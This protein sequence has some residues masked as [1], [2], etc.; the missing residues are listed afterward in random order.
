MR[1]SHSQSDADR[2]KCSHLS[3]ISSRAK[4]LPTLGMGTGT[5]HNRGSP[6]SECQ[7]HSQSCRNS[8]N[9]IVRHRVCSPVDRWWTRAPCYV[10]T[11]SFPGSSKETAP[12]HGHD[13]IT[14]TH[15]I[16]KARPKPCRCPAWEDD[17]TLP[18]PKSFARPP[19][20]I[21]THPQ[22]IVCG[23]PCLVGL[24]LASYRLRQQRRYQCAYELTHKEQ[25]ITNS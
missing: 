25:V 6:M 20:R 8:P 4:G 12:A 19:L 11:T 17:P 15:T 9:R 13:T 10:T 18:S 24:L 5:R 2:E 3:Y 1:K 16:W 7:S 21:R 22:R 23:Y 14:H